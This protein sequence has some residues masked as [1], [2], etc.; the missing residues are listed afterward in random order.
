MSIPL[1]KNGNLIAGA[2]TVALLFQIFY[3][4]WLVY[5][6]ASAGLKFGE[7]G[8]G[9]VFVLRQSSILFVAS[10]IAVAASAA[11]ARRRFSNHLL[12][13]ILGASVFSLGSY[14]LMLACGIV[15]VSRL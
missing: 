7:I 4:L 3:L 14:L 12:S 10:S 5:L 8:N 15:T 1:K 6:S 9:L 2:L 11:W 13:W